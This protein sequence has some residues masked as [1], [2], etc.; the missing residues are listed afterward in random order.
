M[1]RHSSSILSTRMETFKANVDWLAAYKE[2]PWLHDHFKDPPTHPNTGPNDLSI[3]DIFYETFPSWSSWAAWEPNERALQAYALH[4]STR[5]RDR[6]LI[7]DLLALEG[8]DFAIGDGTRRTHYST[9]REQLSSANT[10]KLNYQCGAIKFN[11]SGSR[12]DH[13]RATIDAL[14]KLILD[15]CTKDTGK[16]NNCRMLL[17][18][19]ICL[20]ETINEERL[21]LLEAAFSSGYSTT[22]ISAIC[23]VKIAEKEGRE[24][25]AEKLGFLF[26]ALDWDASEKLRKLL[27]E[28][29][30]A[31]MC[32]H[33][34]KIQRVLKMI[35][36]VDRLWTS[37]EL[38]L[39]EA[40]HLFGEICGESPKL[41]RYFPEETR[42][43]LERWPAKW[44]VQESYQIL[45]LAQSNPFTSTKWLTTQIKTYLLHRLVSP[46]LISIEMRRTKLATRL[47]ESLLHL[48]R[49]TQDHDRRSMALMAAHPDAN[50]GSY[51]SLKCIQQLDFIDDGFLRILKSLIR[52]NKRSSFGEACVSF[53]RALTLEEDLIETW[54][55]PLRLMI[56]EESEKLEKWALETLNLESWVNWVDDVGRIFPDMIHA[57]GKD[58]PIFFTSDLHR[59]VLTLHSNA[60]TLKRLESRDGMRH[61]DAMICILRG[62]D[63]QLCH[64]LE[65]IIGFLNVAS[66]DVKWDT[67]AAL[68]ARLDRNGTNAKTIRES[69]F[70]VSMA[71][72]P[73]VEACLH[74]LESYEEAS[75][76]V[77]KTMLACWLN[78]EDMMDRDCLALESVAMVLG[79]YAEDRLEP[80]LDS[81]EATHAHLDEQFQAL[82]AEAI[83]LEGLRIAFKAKDPNGIALI[84]D[85][86]G[87]EDSFPMDDIMDD[88]P[89]DLI[90]VVERISEHEVELQLPLTKLTAL[91]KRAIGSGTAQ[92]LL[93]RFGP[94]FNGLP[95]NFCFHWD[96][97][98][99]DV[100]VDFHSPCLA[101]PDSQPEEHSCHGR[102]TPGI[103]QL[104]RLFSQHLIDNGFSSLQNIYKFLLSEM[105]SLHTKC[106]VCAVPHAYNMLR[107]TVCKDPQCLK[108]YKKS[109]LDIRLADLRH[110]P[111]AVDLLLTM[112]YASATAAKMSLLPGCP[113]SD[114]TVLR[115]LINRLPSTS[116]LQNAQHIDHSLGQV[117]EV[118]SWAL[119]S[120]R[121]FLVSATAHLKIP[122]FP[123]AHQFL[124]ANASPHLETAFAAKHTL[125]RNTSVVFHGTSVERMYAILTQGLKTLSD[126]ALQ[127]H[128]HAY[129][130]GIYVSTEPATAWAYAQ[131]GGA[132]WNNSGLGHLKVLLA[133]ELTGHWTAASGDIFLVTEPACL[134]VRYVFLMP[135]SADVP[136]GRHVVPALSSVFAGLRRGAL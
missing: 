5:P 128:G 44:E 9:T 91:Q 21:S 35:V 32:N 123:G 29:I 25:D 56:V 58:S 36:N 40:L 59:W 94:G 33:L 30:V 50:L 49:K 134:I 12:P 39:L 13:V 37:S 41:K 110:D 95:P 73:G 77:A 120:Y 46:R 84:L 3:V 124:L 1:V 18:Q 119:T 103:Y 96:N 112:V 47:I 16:H 57:I 55:F 24:P 78:E 97:E 51:L 107:P 27:G 74:V 75:L 113:I 83:R 17:L 68:V 67:F 4:L 64:E 118:L 126:T 82:I 63:I 129:G 136:L 101:L 93:V 79:M 85:E 117:K 71:T 42:T 98:P 8:P 106:L 76:Q 20:N 88:L 114:A 87:V 65:R 133:C 2:A 45:L 7:R 38:R 100:S 22:V 92:S 109:H 111:A 125:H 104:S 132:S 70:Q 62:G 66:E 15:V 43:V 121:G 19:Q 34:Q 102:P 53:A 54:R 130:K 86:V 11:L 31:S 52:N 28:S 23:E 115:K 108:T 48:W 90:D 10:T 135:G 80:T 116:C 99:K 60:A 89:S 131:A 105:A 61:S 122:S 26:K 72:I 127:R 6:I 14:S 69:I 81:L